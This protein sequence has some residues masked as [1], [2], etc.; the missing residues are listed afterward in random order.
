MWYV[1]VLHPCIP[2]SLEHV[3]DFTHQFHRS[4]ISCCDFVLCV[5]HAVQVT[6]SFAHRLHCSHSIV[7]VSEQ[8]GYVAVLDPCIPG[9]LEHVV[10]GMG[11]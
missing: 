5:M 3:V 6:C 2:G 10:K 9:S 8:C 7:G 4:V 1:A 11:W